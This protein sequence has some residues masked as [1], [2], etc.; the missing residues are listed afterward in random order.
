MGWEKKRVTV[1]QVATR[2]RIRGPGR[3]SGNGGA[4]T[5]RNLSRSEKNQKFCGSNRAQ[6]F[7]S[8]IRF[9]PV[10]PKAGCPSAVPCGCGGSLF[11]FGALL[12]PTGTARSKILCEDV[13][14]ESAPDE[15]FARDGRRRARAPR[16]GLPK[17]RRRQ[18]GPARGRGECE[19]FAAAARRAGRP[20]TPHGEVD[21][22]SRERK[23]VPGQEGQR[24]RGGVRA[25]ARAHLR[26]GEFAGRLRQLASVGEV[27]EPIRGVQSLGEPE[28]RESRLETSGGGHRARPSGG[29][30]GSGLHQRRDALRARGGRHADVRGRAARG[31]GERRAAR[32]REN[33]GRRPEK[34]PPHSNVRPLDHV[35]RRETREEK[36][37][38]RRVPTD[39]FSTKGVIAKGGPESKRRV[40]R[41]RRPGP[42]RARLPG[43]RALERSR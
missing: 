27:G 41:V 17:G 42:L 31:R 1:A 15:R 21:P 22:F 19:R 39:V 32:R 16:G 18:R 43:R 25:R 10:R 29:P 37:R 20:A 26:R 14:S 12:R 36:R 13:A 38:E 4:E 24:A 8:G 30:E 3:F 33:A 7:E 11:A 2:A 34:F 9:G 5:A 28:R 35:G 23:G 6:R 40:F